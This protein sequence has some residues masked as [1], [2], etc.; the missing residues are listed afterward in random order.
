[1]DTLGKFGVKEIKV[2]PGDSFDPNF[3]EAMGFEPS[4][5]KGLNDGV[6]ARM[7]NRGYL[8]NSVLLRPIQVTLVKN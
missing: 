7:V 3:Q 5:E 6:V 1:L 2:D 8:C 4:P